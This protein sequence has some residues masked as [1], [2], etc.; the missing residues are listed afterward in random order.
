[1]ANTKISEYLKK[2]VEKSNDAMSVEFGF[3]PFD[4]VNIYLVRRALN[5]QESLWL[6]PCD[7]NITKFYQSVL[8]AILIDFL[9]KNYLKNE[10]T[11]LKI[12]DRYQKG[13]KR[14]EVIEI[15]FEYENIENP[16]KLKCTNKGNNFI[17]TIPLTTLI[18]DYTKLDNSAGNSNRDTFKPMLD[19]LE[20]TLGVRRNIPLFPYKFA[21]VA[22]KNYFED[23]FKQVD[24]KA[25]PYTY[26]SDGGE[27]T[28]SLPLSESMFFV[29]S[30]YATIQ[31]Y[32]FDKDICLDTIIF[33]ENKYNC[34]LQQDIDRNCFQN[35]IF[36]GQQ[37]PDVQQLLR[38][39]WTLPE[40]QYFDGIEEGKIE[41][42]EVKNEVLTQKIVQFMEGIKQL[43]KDH[44]IDLKKLCSYVGYI[45]ALI[46]LSDNSRLKNGIDELSHSFQKKSKQVLGEAF[47]S[48]DSDYKEANRE[49]VKGYQMILEQVYFQNNAKTQALKQ[50]KET[51]Y[52]LIPERQTLQVWRIEIKNLNWLNADVISFSKLK[53]LEKQCS[54]TVLSLEDYNF[55]FAIRNSMHHIKWLLYDMEYRRYKNFSKRYD[56]K[57][58]EEYKSNCRGKLMGIEYPDEMQPETI[59]GVIDRIVNNE[60][61]K[62]EYVTPY[63]NHIDKKI[64]FSNNEN[65]VLST[66]SVVILIDKYDKP[67]KYKVA[68]LSIGDRIRIYENQHKD[69]LFK[70]AANAGRQEIFKEILDNSKLW[71]DKLIQHCTNE[72]KITEIA[73][74]CSVANNIVNG[75]LCDNSNTKF[76]QNVKP[77]KNILGNDYQQILKSKRNYNSI[78][79]ALGRNLSDEISD[80]IITGAKGELLKQFDDDSIKAISEHNM[81]IKTIKQIEII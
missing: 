6:K 25:F 71:K 30:N 69:V 80:Y 57:L 14:Y 67:I 1:M 70:I 53:S 34:P 13:N 3:S 27:E 31:E 62:S 63:H 66:N 17:R 58:I 21:V 7:G 38:W 35:G 42:I 20:K 44:C 65:I 10:K 33:M 47:S 73:N 5:K 81:P 12:G 50:T 40:Y 76:P 49:L 64:T 51:D 41:S 60:S 36:V 68:D 32:I 56:N 75:W 52:L 16:V 8:F 77:L 59:D 39:R 61:D 24:K 74:E 22:Q 18:N 15:N 23:C 4:R 19:F 55:Y 72:E 46:V 48:T 43:E 79:I 45:Y 11:Q 29:V 28:K 9:K 37:E 26:I 2:I 54:I 78:M